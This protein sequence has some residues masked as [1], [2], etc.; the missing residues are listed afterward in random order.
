MGV[1][2]KSRHGDERNADDIGRRSALE[3]VRSEDDEAD[4]D[5]EDSGIYP[6]S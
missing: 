2:I 4:A 6:E 3:V 1:L 5:L